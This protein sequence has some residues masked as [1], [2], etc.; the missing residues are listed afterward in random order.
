MQ[1]YKINYYIEL[2]RKCCLFDICCE[3][4]YRYV[5]LV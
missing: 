2:P 4:E 5:E 1:I 3:Y